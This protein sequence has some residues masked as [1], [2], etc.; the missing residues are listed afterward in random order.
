M[1]VKATTTAMVLA[2]VMAGCATMHAH[3]AAPA[4]TTGTKLAE[5]DGTSFD[6]S[7]ARLN[8]SAMTQ[9]ASVAQTM[10]QHPDLKVAV[11]GYA[12]ASGRPKTNQRLSER[13]ARMVADAL[14]AK[15]VPVDH[16]SVRGYGEAHPVADNAT[17]AGRSKNRRV[18]IVVE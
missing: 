2:M 6:S 1:G 10:Q 5:I 7:K 9:V 11:N 12:D 3:P 16:L 18:E 17:P 14:V 13:R 4:P 8:E 15:G